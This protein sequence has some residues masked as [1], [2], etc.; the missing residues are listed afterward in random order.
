MY[1][2]A[3]AKALSNSSSSDVNVIALTVAF[4]SG[5]IDTLAISTFSS[6]ASTV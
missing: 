4:A 1:A 3:F 6:H 5:L 2:F